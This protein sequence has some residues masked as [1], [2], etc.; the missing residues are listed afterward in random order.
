MQGFRFCFARLHLIPAAA[1]RYITTMTGGVDDAWAEKDQIV[2]HRANGGGAELHRTNDDLQEQ[3]RGRNPCNPFHF[4]RQDVGEIDNEIGIELSESE[5]KRSGQH[6][7][8]ELRCQAI[9]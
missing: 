3:N 1:R 4:E 5:E 8:A 7:C 9:H 6:G 2:S